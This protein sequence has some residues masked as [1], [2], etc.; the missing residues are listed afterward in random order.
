MKVSAALWS[1]LSRGVVALF[2]AVLFISTAR[3]A[4]ACD[5]NCDGFAFVFVGTPAALGTIVVAPLVGLAFDRGPDSPYG[6]ALGATILAA[7]VGWGI[8]AAV[9]LPDGEISETATAG[10]IV[11]PVLAGVTA[12]VMVYRHW[13]DTESDALLGQGPDVWVAPSAGGFSI[14]L[15]WRL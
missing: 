9:T 14:G 12:T 1:A 8:G 7:A 4:H 13:V 15:T 6:E 11:L 5:G 3:E 10:L 2:V